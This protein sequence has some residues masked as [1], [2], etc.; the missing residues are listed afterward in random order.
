MVLAVVKES[1]SSF[2]T[3][4]Q[5]QGFDA[6]IEP[7]LKEASDRWIA[8]LKN[9]KDYSPHTLKNYAHDLKSYILFLNEHLGHSLKVQD[10]T[11][12][13][14]SDLR[15]FLSSRIGKSTSNR[16]NK[17]MI[18][19][20]RSF[21][22]FLSRAYSLESD[23]YLVLDSPRAP[24]TLP[25]PVSTKDAFA[26]TQSI[27]SHSETWVTLRD[28]ALF[29]LLYGAGLRISEALNL[30]GHDLMRIEQNN[31]V[32]IKGKGKKER[33]VPILESVQQKLIAYQKSHPFALN[34][35]EPIF[36]GVQGNILNASMAQKAMRTIRYHLGLPD[37]VTPHSLRHSYA[38]HLLQ[39]GA[40]LRSIQ[41]LLGHASLSTTQKYTET[42]ED[43]LIAVHKNFH[44]RS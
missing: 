6:F 10:I 8:F 9:E 28:Q 36:R 22:R 12:V 17:R 21:S 20:L 4:S 14:L 29:T 31:A 24:A 27:A 16:T 30:T 26:I 38:T 32:I 25:R 2:S 3:F 7:C 44:P 19:T 1:I 40:D 35:D 13:T 33:L 42:D 39:S 41:E 43:H 18:S 15:S 23:S 5:E 34:L 11:D 37:S